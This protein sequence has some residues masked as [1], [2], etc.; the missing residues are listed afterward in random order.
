MPP[1]DNRSDREASLGI[2]LSTARSMAGL[3]RREDRSCAL[4]RLQ[5]RCVGKADLSVMRA[6]SALTARADL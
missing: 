3:E 1:R 6:R 5:D 4:H 2:G